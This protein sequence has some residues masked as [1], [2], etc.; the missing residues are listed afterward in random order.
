MRPLIGQVRRLT[1]FALACILWTHAFFL[2][3]LP[4]PN[5]GGLAP[6]LHLTTAEI[7]VFILL[8]SFSLLASYG[9]GRI[10]TDILYIYF[11]PFVLLWIVLKWIYKVLVVVN[12]FCM[13]G[14]SVQ[15][16]T[17]IL[18]TVKV[19]DAA[20]AALPR[21][22]EDKNFTWKA[23]LHAIIRPFR[24]FT[25]LWC[26]L[27]LLT[28]HRRLM[29]LALGIVVIHVA[30]VL[31]AILQVTLFSAGVLSNLESRISENTDTWLGKVASVT[32]D[33]EP[34]QDLRT[35]WMNLTGIKTALLLLQN[36]QLVSRW[37]AVLG[38]AFLACVHLYLA[39][40]FSFIY[41]GAANVQGVALNW[42]IALVTSAFMPFSYTDLP[43]NFWVKLAGGIHSLVIVAI[44]AGTIINYVTRRA[45][46][47]HQTAI[48]LSQRFTS[49]DV[50]SRL[51]ILEE[52][53]KVAEAP[54]TSG[55]K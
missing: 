52:K 50:Q 12:R 11:F 32:R 15:A 46:D 49:E 7:V 41:Y 25:I 6:R 34:T 27:L 5:V 16:P 9:L 38:S 51:V 48:V 14:T 4:P 22:T 36:R 2:L 30:F 26:F 42:P 29:E 10:L 39:F 19:I 24:N 21:S 44:G 43:L 45:Q 20:P 53:F 17:A 8:F 54:P 55:G 47:L 23:V 3:R 35:A 40:L 37:A 28:T 33:T 31:K 1:R 18:P 13:A